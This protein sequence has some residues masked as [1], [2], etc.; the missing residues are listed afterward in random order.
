MTIAELNRLPIE[1]VEKLYKANVRK[2]HELKAST[3]ALRS[4]LADLQE[5]AMHQ[6]AL[7][8]AKS[9]A[10]HNASTGGGMP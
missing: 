2:E 6:K 4:R 5:V 8:E 9:K 10:A 3:R 7:D 1:D